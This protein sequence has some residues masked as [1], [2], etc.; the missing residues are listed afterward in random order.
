MSK[1]IALIVS[2]LFATSMFAAPAFAASHAK[3]PGGDASAM[4]DA[5][6]KPAKKKAKKAKKADAMASGEA[7]AMK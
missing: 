6:A 4:G 3:A 7:S 5:S 2:G 1:V